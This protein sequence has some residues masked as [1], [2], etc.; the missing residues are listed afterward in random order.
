MRRQPNRRKR[1]LDFLSWYCGCLGLHA[2]LWS[3]PDS[4]SRCHD[5]HYCRGRC[6]NC[7]I[8][9]AAKDRWRREQA[10]QARCIERI[11]GRMHQDG[12]EH[13]VLVL[14]A[15]HMMITRRP[16]RATANTTKSKIL[17]L[18]GMS[19]RSWEGVKNPGKCHKAQRLPRRTAPAKGP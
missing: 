6:G 9:V 3:I 14:L 10:D 16:T 5:K 11:P 18:G 19:L 1:D 8:Q 15:T 7:K 12:H 4:S 17:P 13:A 2:G